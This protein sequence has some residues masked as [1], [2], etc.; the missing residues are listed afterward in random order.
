M[1]FQMKGICDKNDPKM[2]KYR[3]P[4][5]FRQWKLL[6]S[7]VILACILYAFLYYASD[8]QI[9]TNNRG[10]GG[11]G[12]ALKRKLTVVIN[13]FKRHEMMEGM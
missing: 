12:K 6:L 7:L 11:G 2:N 9:S 1:R 8:Q 10:G 5:L 4:S 13:T 3:I